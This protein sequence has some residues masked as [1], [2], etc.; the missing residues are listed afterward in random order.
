LCFV[1]LIALAILN[2]LNVIKSKKNISE[3][4]DDL[5]ENKGIILKK[6]LVGLALI[7]I[8]VTPIIG[9]SATI[10][11]KVNETIPSAGGNMGKNN[12]S[13]TKLIEFLKKNKTNE[14]YS[15]VVSSARS[16]QDIIIQ[17]GGSVRALG[18]FSGS[19]NILTNG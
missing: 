18:G 17:T 1:S 10:T 16:S 19:D 13:N 9:A 11:Y 6:T 12:S 3:N 5:K 8:L 4:N 15:L 2:I 14:K 7:G